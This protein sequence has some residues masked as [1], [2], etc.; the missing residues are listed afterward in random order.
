MSKDDWLDVAIKLK[1]DG[2]SWTNLPD[3]LFKATGEKHS[4]DEIRGRLRRRKERQEHSS[5]EKHG[6]EEKKPKIYKEEDTYTVVS[7]SR[8]SEHIVKITENSLRQLKKLYCLERLTINQVCREMQ[9]PRRDFYLVKTAFGIT[10]DDVPV[11]DEDLISKETDDLVEDSLQEKKRLYFVR[12]QQKEIEQLRKE[13]EQYRKKDYFI[14]KLRVMA[15]ELFQDMS[16]N[17]K[18]PVSRESD[19]KVASNDIMLEIAVVDLHLSKLAW[20]PEVG[21][22]YDYKIAEK[23]YR[24]AIKYAYNRALEVQPGRILLPVGNDF[25]H[26]DTI[27]GTTTAGTLQDYDGRWQKQFQRGTEL[28]IWTAD[29]CSEIADVELLVVP[30]NHDKMTSYFALMVL[31]AWFKDRDDVK[32]NMDPKTRKYIEFGK[33]LIG[34]TH[35]DK[36]KKRLYGNMQVEAPQSWGRTKYRE[37]HVGHLHHEVTNEEHGVIVRY[38]STLTGTD[39]YHFEHGYVGSQQ[40]SQAF[41]WHKN[42]GLSDIWFC[43]VE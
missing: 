30:G 16:V 10:K 6:Y 26:T 24:N 31:N 37:F 9:I 34:F 8:T 7:R 32:I 29:L 42:R 25:F 12:L 43:P 14:S 36:E 33:N 2:V 40:K 21:E 17:Y 28:L 27:E 38:L 23:R 4:Y 3:E 15:D 11:I 5:K 20:E 22:N 41:L 35:G 19:V 39:A 13:N 1:N 18:G